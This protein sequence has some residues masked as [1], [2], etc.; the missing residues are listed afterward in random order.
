MR[1]PIARAAAA[2]SLARSCCP[3][4]RACTADALQGWTLAEQDAWI[5]APTGPAAFHSCI[6]IVDATYIRIERPAEYATERRYYSTYKKTHAMFFLAI[7]DRTGQR[8]SSAAM[9]TVSAVSM[10]HLLIRCM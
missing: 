4:P 7:V 8:A 2:D 3:L 5:A 9:H 1:M 10:P 6:G